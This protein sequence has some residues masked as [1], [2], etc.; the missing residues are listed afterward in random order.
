VT[1]IEGCS[2]HPQSESVVKDPYV[3]YVARGGILTRQYYDLAVQ[4]RLPGA[5]LPK[6]S[7]QAC[8]LQAT[9]MG[10]STGVGLTEEEIKLYMCLR[11]QSADEGYSETNGKRGPQSLSDHLLLAEVFKITGSDQIEKFT[12]KFPNIFPQ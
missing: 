5:L 6:G 2:V 8:R 12:G 9:R 4:F 3:D 7:Y 1:L 10:E 11:N